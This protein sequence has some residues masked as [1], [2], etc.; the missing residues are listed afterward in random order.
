VVNERESTNESPAAPD[1]DGGDDRAGHL[2]FVAHEVRNPL[3]TALWTA[4]LL[5]RMT[6]E[7]RGSPRGEKL[8]AMCLRSLGRVRQLVEDHFLVER[9]DAGGL[10]M[11][12]EPVLL[13]DALDAIATRG[14][15]PEGGEVDGRAAVFA[16]RNLLERALEAVIRAAGR[17]AAPVRLDVRADGEVVRVRIAGAP[18][19]PDALDDP[20]K[21]SPSDTKN[22]ALG[23]SAARRI[24]SAAGGRLAL[25]GEAFVL[26]LPRIASYVPPLDPDRAR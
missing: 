10:P 5:V 15:V 18:P 8:A 2:G 25:D 13:R 12:P 6:G 14:A 26:T 22:S 20:R 19:A 21:G 7:E 23:L 16:D 3:S 17:D 1:G 9:L 11:R 24:A 4:E